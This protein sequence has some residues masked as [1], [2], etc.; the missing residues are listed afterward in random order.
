MS[1]GTLVMGT[2]LLSAVTAVSLVSPHTQTRVNVSVGS[3]AHEQPSMATQGSLCQAGAV[4]A[5]LQPLCCPPAGPAAA[6]ACC[7]ADTPFSPPAT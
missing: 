2:A 1:Y 5:A 4:V 7:T 3:E 6:P